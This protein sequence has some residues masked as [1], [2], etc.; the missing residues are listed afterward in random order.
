M[1]KPTLGVH[2][3][4]ITLSAPALQTAV[5]LAERARANKPESADTELRDLCASKGPVRIHTDVGR[6]GMFV[7]GMVWRS[8]G[9]RLHVGI[10]D[11]EG[12]ELRAGDFYMLDPKVPHWTDCP[13]PDGWLIF[14]PHITLLDKRSVRKLASDIRLGI[15]FDLLKIETSA[16]AV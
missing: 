13:S 1:A 15:I 12:T 4:G 14:S 9:H 3:L 11:K 7:V 2:R 10:G 16:E 8:D 5:A 6:P